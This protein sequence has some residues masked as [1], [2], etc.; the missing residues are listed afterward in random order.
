MAYLQNLDL[1]NTIYKVNE[2]VHFDNEWFYYLLSS[3]LPWYYRIVPVVVELPELYDVSILMDRLSKD[4][5]LVI[6]DKYLNSNRLLLIIVTNK[7]LMSIVQILQSY[8]DVNFVY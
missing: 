1:A 4:F 5:S 7:S 6:L 8:K 3:P 2:F